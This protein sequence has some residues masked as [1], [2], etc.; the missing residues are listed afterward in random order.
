[1][2]IIAAKAQCFYE[3]LHPN[4]AVYAKNVKSNAQVMAKV[5]MDSGIHVVSGGTEC[6]MFT[7]D[8]SNK[9]LS[10]RQYADLLEKHSITVNKNSVPGDQRSFVETSGIR[11]GTAAETTRRGADTDWFIQLANRMIRLLRNGE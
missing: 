1:M 9:Q 7:V 11:I 2:H 10:G 4:F 3:A 8:L 6:H 5:F